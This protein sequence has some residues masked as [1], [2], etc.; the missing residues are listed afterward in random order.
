MPRFFF[1]LVRD[2]KTLIDDE[3]SNLDSLTDAQAEAEAIIRE[4]AEDHLHTGRAFLLNL[5]RVANEADTVLA[6][7]SSAQVL[8][9]IFFRDPFDC[10]P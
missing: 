5:V 8:G 10:R 1:H 4:L 6:E 9:G 3:G 2:D 7:V